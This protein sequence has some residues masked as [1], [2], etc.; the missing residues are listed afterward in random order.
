MKKN[1]LVVLTTIGLMFSLWITQAQSVGSWKSYFS[2]QSAAMVVETPHAVYAV[3][4]SAYPTTSVNESIGSLMSYSLEDQRIETYSLEDGL[5][6]VSIRFLQYS[7]EA[8]ALLLIYTNN[9]I[10]IFLGKNNVYNLPDIKNKPDL[11]INNVEIR[12]KYAYISVNTGIWV[13]NLERKEI[14]TQYSI[15]NTKATCE[16]NGYH[17]AATVDGVYRASTSKSIIQLRDKA[18]WEQYSIPAVNDRNITKFAV[19]QNHLIL[20]VNNN[21]VWTVAIDGTT[22][23]LF[24]GTCRQIMVNQNQFVI[25]VWSLLLV[26]SNNFVQST[27][28]LDSDIRNMAFSKDGEDSYWVAWGNKGLWKIKTK[29]STTGRLEHDPLISELKVNSPLRNLSFDLNFTN[30]KLLVTGGSRGSNRNNVTGTFMIYEN[31]QWLSLDRDTVAPGLP[32]RDFMSAVSDPR[33][34]NRYF[35]STWGEGVYEFRDTTFIKL[36][37]Y[38]NSSLISILDGNP[39]YIRTDGMAFDRNN[40]LYVANVQNGLNVLS[41]KD[42]K[43]YSIKNNKLPGSQINHVMATR[44]GKVWINVWRD[45]GVDCVDCVTAIYALDH[46]GTIDYDGDDTWYI[47]RMFTDQQARKVAEKT[48]LCMA[49]DLTGTIWVGTD[50]GLIYF[51]SAEQMGRGS[52]NRLYSMDEKGEVRYLYEGQRVTAI[53]VDGANR[54]WI[55][56]QG[57][58]VSCLDQSKELKATE[59]HTKNSPILSDNINAIVIDDQTGEVFIATDLG[60]CSYMGEAISGLPDYSNIRVYPNPVNPARQS[61]VTITGLMQNSVIKITDLA[62]NL[63]HENTSLGGQYIWN[64]TAWNSEWVKAGIYLVFATLPDGS[65]GIVSKIIVIR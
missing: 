60:L 57:S 20:D 6:D 16:W 17:Y 52:C 23:N 14:Q 63:I 30:N 27:L 7:P 28:T 32:C 39:R 64:C 58:G 51:S 29:A 46:N 56:T 1:K 19:F 62:G 3:Y 53:A 44:D 65:E 54:K 38:N 49:E 4:K 61:R 22:K 5:N 47:G 10:D 26:F 15:G 43:W 50:N 55:G 36:H 21:S 18:N 59:Y 45:G 12:G 9:N 35:V 2:Y 31:G 33:D 11:I 41:A 8:N 34:P 48:Y 42:N 37:T 40:N 13:I 24:N 25:T